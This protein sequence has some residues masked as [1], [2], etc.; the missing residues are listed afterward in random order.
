[1]GIVSK[2]YVGVA[3]LFTSGA[4]LAGCES[5]ETAASSDGGNTDAQALVD[6]APGCVR[7]LAPENRTRFVVVSRPYGDEGVQTNRWEVLTLSLTGELTSTDN[8]FTMGRATSGSVVFTPD[9]K[10]GFVPQSDGTIGVFRIGSGD[11][12]TVLHEAWD[13]GYYASGLEMSPAGDTLQVLDGNWRNNGGGLYRI[14]IDCNDDTLSDEGLIS[15]SKLP[16]GIQ[17]SES[18]ARIVAALD[19]GDSPMDQDV[20]LVLDGNLQSPAVSTRVFPD[21]DA[22]VGPVSITADSKYV[23]LGDTSEF[24]GADT[25]IGVA[26]VGADSL[27]AVQLLTPIP[28]P[29]AIATSPYNDAALVVSG[30]GDAIYKLSYDPSNLTT[31]FVNLG[32]LS[33]TGGRPALPGDIVQ[34]NRGDLRGLVII[35]ENQGLRRV[36]FDDN[37]EVSDLGRTEF[38][39]SFAGII[40][41]LGIQP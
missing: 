3:S 1:M 11:E 28:D 2:L 14:R 7:E 37:G 31:P 23:L 17:R 8:F 22:I 33:Y 35:A 30:F 34:I 9:G 36:R 21:R 32:E 39:L 29:Y 4:L 10:L 20:H 15:A 38:A 24:S 18:G 12:I 19:L 16:R 27:D 41:A 6:A 5:G 13:A 25:R 26:R 40:G